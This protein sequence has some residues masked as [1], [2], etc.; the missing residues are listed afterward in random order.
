ML[1]RLSGSRS[2]ALLHQ[3]LKPC[4]VASTTSSRNF[5][6]ST[7]QDNKYAWHNKAW[8]AFKLYKE[9]AGES[10]GTVFAIGLASY[11][12]SKEIFIIN[13][14]VLLLFIMGG[15]GYHLSKLIGPTVG[16]MLDERRN[17]IL[18]NMNRGKV[19]KIAMLEDTIAAE[20][21]GEAAIE[22]RKEFFEIA[23]SNNELRM[24]YEYRRRLHEVEDE[25]Q[26]RLDYQV[27]LQNL[28]LSIE[29]RH[30]ASWIEKEVVK[31]ITEEQE[32]DALLQCIRDLN[33][34]ADSKA[35]A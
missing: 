5:T 3:I 24:E 19:A 13:D 15:T 29:E 23:Q 33:V 12:F 21:E 27:D 11:I 18:D 16:K 30:M 35:V 25:V 26:K 4:V 28:E 22:C 9:M 34:L 17:D 20:K 1:S 32:Q 7:H 2:T 14:E 31:S 10:A 8:P 6:L